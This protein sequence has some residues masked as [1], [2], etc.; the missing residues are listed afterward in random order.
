MMKDIE[1]RDD[2]YKLLEVFYSKAFADDLIGFYFTEVIKLDLTTHL[3]IITDFWESVL[4]NTKAY[5]GDVM[6]L[7]RHIHDLSPFKPVHFDRWVKIFT[8]TVDE[9]FA[10]DVAELAKQRAQSIATIM[11]IKLVYGGITH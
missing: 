9:Y 1:E 7:H 3:P 6:K 4:L 10:G 5:R 8:E 2:I 11:K